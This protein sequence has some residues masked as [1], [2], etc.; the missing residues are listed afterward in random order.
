MA[1]SLKKQLKQLL[2]FAESVTDITKRFTWGAGSMTWSA[3]QTYCRQYATD[4]AKVQS[5]LEND[6]L[7]V[8]L[9]GSQAWIGLT[10][11]FWLWSDGSEP[12]FIPWKAQEPLLGGVLDCGLLH[13][14]T[15]PFGMLDGYCTVPQ[16]FFC[17]KGKQIVLPLHS[18]TSRSLKKC[19]RK[20]FT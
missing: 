20:S 1:E 8:M 5:Q 12:S 4:L 17:Y 14:S 10:G 3:A 9:S 7:Q 18:L 11:L 2:L 13:Y 15:Y 16:T 6:R 19:L